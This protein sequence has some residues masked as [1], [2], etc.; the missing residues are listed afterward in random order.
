MDIGT[1]DMGNRCIETELTYEDG[2]HLL[3]KTLMELTKDG[4]KHICEISIL[5]NL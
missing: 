5:H 4:S 1:R 2:L 3:T